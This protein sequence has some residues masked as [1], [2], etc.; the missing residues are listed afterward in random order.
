MRNVLQT[1]IVPRVCLAAA[2][3]LAVSG[4][5]QA[6]NLEAGPFIFKTWNYEVSTTYAGGVDGLL[7]F[8]TSDTSYHTE[9]YGLIA[10]DATDPRHRLFTGNA[11]SADDLIIK[12]DASV[13]DGEDG[14]GLLRITSLW[15]GD[16]TGGDSRFGDGSDA[17]LLGNDITP[18]IRYWKEGDN[19]EYLLGMF[20]GSQDQV[21]EVIR[22]NDEYRIWSSSAEFDVFEVV[23]AVAPYNPALDPAHTPAA[24]ID[25]DDFDGWFDRNTDELALGGTLSYFRFQGNATDV[26]NLDGET[27]VLI[28]I[29]RGSFV[30]PPFVFEDWWTAPDGSGLDVWQSWNIGDPFVFSNGWTGSEDSARGFVAEVVT[31][32]LGDFV[33]NDTDADGIQDDG[34]PGVPGVTVYLY[35][36]DGTFVD[37]TLTAG[38]GSYLFDDLD[39][40]D[41]YVEFVLPDGYVFSP[42][43]QGADDAKDSDADTVTGQTICT[44]L[45][46]GEDDD[47]WD[48]GLIQ[49]CELHVAVEG[50]V[51][52]PPPPPSG[53]D[54]QGKVIRMTLEY[55]GQDCAASSHTQEAKKVS[56][57]GDPAFAEPVSVLVMDKKGKKTYAS[58]TGILVGD[59]IVVDADN[60]GKDTLDSEVRVYIDNAAGETIQEIRFHTSCSQPLNVGDQFG[61]LLLTSLTSTEGGE[62]GETP[63][64]PPADCV[65]E[66]PADA[67]AFDVEYTYTITNAGAG[68]TLTNVTVIDDMFG[69][70]PGSPIASIPP[71]QSVELTL[72]VPLTEE[73]TNTVTVVGFA[74]ISQ[75]EDSDSATITKPE[76]PPPL[77]ECT[78][79]VQAMLLRYTGPDIFDATIEIV[80]DKIKNTPV[81]YTGVDL[82][83]GLILSSPQE[84]GFTIDATAHGQRELGAKTKIYING[85]EEK[86]HTSCSTPFVSDAPAPLDKP[87]GDPSPNWFVV[88]FTQK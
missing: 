80:A 42:Q 65:T 70:V 69:E 25:V 18:N 71:G 22:A 32:R 58:Q 87:K 54:C 62:V 12:R 8:R 48:A 5:T 52:L 83:P 86:L 24:R 75:C 63:Q 9:E 28:E 85:V 46:P 50:C 2:L 7:Y 60:A 79:K 4:A 40:G 35:Q 49:E 29:T 67:V 57:D 61:S 39:P 17:T 14:F 37:V 31:A 64:D 38:D 43:D 33:W 13:E 1:R 73:T 26:H 3:I 74:G 20:W 77:E 84:N 55:T 21:V 19:D 72:I 68:T 27:E 10:Y 30:T 59:S 11:N 44:T 51:I 76:G 41:Y 56:C 66:M 82:T 78:T 88:N 81:V 34:E 15:A 23:S 53:N 47:T 6:A 36:C 45:E 16:V